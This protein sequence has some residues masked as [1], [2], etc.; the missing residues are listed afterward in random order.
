[1]RNLLCFLALL[2]LPASVAAQGVGYTQEVATS[3]GTIY[4]ITVTTASLDVMSAVPNGK[5]NGAYAVEVFNLASSTQ[6]I[7]CAYDSNVST[8][9]T[10]NFYGREVPVGQGMVWQVLQGK[11]SV[12][13]RSQGVTVGGIRATVTQVR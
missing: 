1:M 2:A 5:L 12:F 10:S 6:T 8:T 9:S 11:I 13:C 3:T 7:N 4:T